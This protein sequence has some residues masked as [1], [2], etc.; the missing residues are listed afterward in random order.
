MRLTF[1][2]KMSEKLWSET[3]TMI[4]KPTT[5]QKM[6]FDLVGCSYCKNKPVS[7]LLFIETSQPNRL[8]CNCLCK[9]P[10]KGGNRITQRQIM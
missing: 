8:L 6:R 7:C 10:T 5:K 3:E 4:R 2:N 1:D 9:Y